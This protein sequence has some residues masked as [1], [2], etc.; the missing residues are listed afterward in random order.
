MKVIHSNK[1]ERKG[2]A[3]IA[4]NRLHQALGSQGVESV[5]LV[6]SKSSSDETVKTRASTSGRVTAKLRRILDKAY[7]AFRGGAR[8][9]FSTGMVPSYLTGRI[10]NLSPDI[11]HL[12]WVADGY[13]SIRDI[14]NIDHPIVWTLHDMWP[15]TG[16]CHYSGVCSRYVDSC[17][18]CPILRRSS[19]G[20]LSSEVLGRKKQLW[21]S[22]LTL[23]APS[24]WMAQ[25]AETS[26]VFSDSE[27]YI[28]PNGLNTERYC[29]KP[30]LMPAEFGLPNDRQIVLFGGGTATKDPRKGYDLLIEALDDM[31]NRSEYVLMLFGDDNPEVGATKVETQVVGRLD[32]KDLIRLYSVADITAVPSR[33]ESFGQTASEALSC[34]TP[35]VA[36]EGTG[37]AD[38][39]T[40][41]QTGYLASQYSVSDFQN[42]IKWLTQSSD[43]L[44]E[45]S[46][47]ARE[48]AVNNYDIDEVCKQYIELYER[49][50]Q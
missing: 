33:F 42:G 8:D 40:H 15:I 3:A 32:Q 9:E 24:T 29:P 26:S 11:V 7:V 1:F 23:V 35:V 16:G 38:I 2:G 47:K 48:R 18:R 27:V 28:I 21:R 43:R 41:K 6:E 22:D 5:M 4:A 34:G 44:K 50:M 17:G 45:L 37:V 10:D 39:V 12:H 20:D 36:F 25:R 14:S 31:D 30:D 19:T 46:T 49:I 13:Q